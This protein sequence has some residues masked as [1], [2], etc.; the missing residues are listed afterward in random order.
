MSAFIYRFAKIF[1]PAQPVPA[2]YRSIFLHLFLDMAWYG[3]LAGTTV[4]FIAV[5]ATRQGATDRQIGLLSAV[6]GLVNLLFS[7]P[8]GSWLSKRSLGRAVFWTSVMQRAFYLALLPLPVLIMP[9]EQVWVI[10]IM[11]L[12]MTIPGTA[13]VVGF[14][15]QFGEVVPL[16]WRGYVAGTRNALLAVISTVFTLL[17]GWILDRVTFPTGYQ[18]VFAIGVLGAAMS[19]L[20]LYLLASAIGS[21][22]PNGNGYAQQRTPEG[23]KLVLEARALYQRGVQSLRLD[24]MRGPYA[25]IMALLFGWHLVQFMTIPTVTPFIVNQLQ[26]SDQLI[27][28][29]QGLFNITVFLG[30]LGLNNATNRFGN[31]TV[32]GIGVMGLSLFPIFTSLG[33]A[34]FMAANLVGGLAWSMAGGAIYNYILENVPANDRPAH[35]A[36]YSLVSN[37]AILIGSLVGPAIALSIG[38]VLALVLFGIGRFLAGAAILKWG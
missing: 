28:L 33:T 13:L 31:K 8:A 21:R 34:G 20:H 11:T 4:A 32:T 2:A 19:S 23:R 30:S 26:I 38:P 25:R 6:P 29:S 35:I 7:L 24:A 3:V 15:A 37:A 10:I 12:F 5:Y 1:R 22:P 16:E 18:I 36:W 17:S 27:G 14:N 9:R